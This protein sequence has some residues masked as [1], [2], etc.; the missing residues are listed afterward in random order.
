MRILIMDEQQDERP[1]LFR[2]WS[3]WYALVIGFQLLL[4]I[5]FYLLTKFFS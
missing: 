3:H 1:P 5:F 2:K 4:I